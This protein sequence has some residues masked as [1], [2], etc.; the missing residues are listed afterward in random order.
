MSYTTFDFHETLF[1]SK[2][3]GQVTPDAVTKVVAAWGHSP[4]GGGSWE[5]GFVLALNDGRFA[6]ITGWCDYTG[7][8]CQDGAKITYYDAL[9]DWRAFH[10]NDYSAEIIAADL[11]DEEPADLNRYVAGGYKEADRYV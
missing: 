7:W 4:E 5:G 8:G 9:P 2:I 1:N 6:Y 11:W 3:G 10:A